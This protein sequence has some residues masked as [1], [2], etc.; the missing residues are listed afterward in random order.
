MSSSPIKPINAAAGGQARFF[1][2]SAVSVGCRS[3]VLAFLVTG[4]SGCADP[5]AIDV[6]LS[7]DKP[8][9][10]IDHA[11]WGWPFRWRRVSDFALASEEE[12]LL[13]EIRSTDP[14]GCSARQL[15]IVYG[16]VPAGFYQVAPEE[17]ARPAR[18][19]SGRTY[20]VGAT[21]TSSVYRAVFALP[22]A[23][24]GMPVESSGVQRR[25]DRGFQSPNPAKPAGS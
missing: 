11:D 24:L 14:D 5:T 23:R 20:Y 1:N 9:F 3:A 19:R 21:G 6:D 17:N 18:L 25:E 16:D 22:V 4:L 15:A 8:R 12:G 2:V 7:A 13:W 10:T